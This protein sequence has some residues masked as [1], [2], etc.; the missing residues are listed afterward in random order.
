MYTEGPHY[1]QVQHPW[2]TLSA[3]AKLSHPYP[4]NLIRAVCL[5]VASEGLR[6]TVKILKSHFQ[7]FGKIGSDIYMSLKGILALYKYKNFKIVSV[8]RRL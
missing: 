5:H 6:I 8:Q 4:L 1:L 2:I 7:F 3:G